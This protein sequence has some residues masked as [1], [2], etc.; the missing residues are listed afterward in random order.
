MT[1]VPRSSPPAAVIMGMT[2]NGL[3]F[4]RSLGRRGI[5]VVM[6]ESERGRTGM[7][8]RYGRPLWMPDIC[9]A[10]DAWLRALDDLAGQAGAPPVLIPTGDEHVLFVSENRAHLQRG[11]RFRIPPAGVAETLCNKRLQYECLIARG[12]PIPRTAFPAGGDEV[13]ALART[14]VGFPCVIKPLYSHRWWRHRTGAKLETAADENRLLAAYERMVGAGET[15]LLQ[16]LIPGD[17]SS[18]HGYLA[19]YGADARP[20]A[21]ITKQKLRQYPPGFGNGS[22]QVSTR[23]P[24]LAELSDR[25]L[26]TFDYQGLVGIEYKWDF[27]DHSYKLIEINPRSV[28][29]NQ[30]AID[31]GVDLPFCNYQDAIGRPVPAVGDYRAGVRWLNLGLDAQA[32]IARRRE[33]SCRLLGWLRS[34]WGVSSFALFSP[35]D[36]GP[37]LSHLLVAAKVI[38]R[39]VRAAARRALRRQ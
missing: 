19:Y 32:F 30:L 26:R 21:A 1:K 7:K 12:F 29:G 4:A 2:T 11:F 27:R 38:S 35:G 17:D 39:R 34:L 28:S 18:F 22:L 37:F 31:S 9:S 36:P 24:E 6:M 14:V 8:S 10:P 13:A 5:S 23:N 20:L 25:I 3:S 33:G 15:V 16:E